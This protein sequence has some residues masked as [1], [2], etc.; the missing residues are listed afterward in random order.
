M[1]T[2]FDRLGRWNFQRSGATSAFHGDDGDRVH[3]YT[4][5]AEASD[6]PAP[7]ME[8]ALLHGVGSAASA[9]APIVKHLRPRFRRIVI[10]EAPAHG[11]SDRGAQALEA[12][13]LYQRMKAFL[14]D[15]LTGPFVLY[16][17][18]L[19]GGAAVRYASEHPDRVAALVLLSPAGAAVE[20]TA[21]DE[22]KSKFEFASN[23]EA[24]AFLQKLF[25]EPP[26][27]LRLVAGDLKRRLA[28]PELRHFF[29]AATVDD[30]LT[31]EQL[32][33][34]TMPVLF[35]WGG[36]EQVLPPQHLQWYREHLPESAAVV[37]PA[38]YGHSAYV[39]Y[40]EDV[41]KR[42]LAF[43]TA[44]GVIDGVADA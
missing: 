10:P 27:Y 26:W 32:K 16:G 19:G 8:A 29:E 24:H 31:P 9:F 40:P 6:G 44:R 13:S 22:L 37:E 23:T 11:F 18:S 38:N 14:D 1:P 15:A 17:N 21:F 42:M 5:E 33:P 2:L 7:T 30:L 25:H 12:E 35:M 3:Y 39:E 41:A 36:A 20:P 34:L 4:V 28:R 43:L